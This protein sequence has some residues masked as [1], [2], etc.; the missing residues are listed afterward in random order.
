M[1]K[2]KKKATKKVAEKEVKKSKKP[3]V[4][5][6]KAKKVAKPEKEVKKGKKSAEKEEAPAKKAKKGFP[7]KGSGKAAK[8]GKTKKKKGVFLFKAPSDFKPHFLLVT[9]KVAKDGLITALGSEAIR[10]KGKFDMKAEEKKKSYLSQYDYPTLASIVGRLG[11]ITYKA[12]KEKFYPLDPKG[13]TVDKIKGGH[14]L[15]PTARFGILL[16][17]G[18]K[19]A[20]QT[21]TCGVKQVFQ[22]VEVNG[23][24]KPVE[25]DKKK[26]PV[27]RIIRRSAR[28]LPSCFENSLMPP[29]KRRGKASDDE[30]GE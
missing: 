27:C 6:K 8:A 26:D 7:A 20:D 28:L 4:A 30:A 2:D 23:K 13:R 5:E 16:R 9:V 29:K 12:T 17:A 14:R 22:L 21:L 24:V 15:P 1:S 11:A 19:V 18:R 3:A 10:Y 25:L